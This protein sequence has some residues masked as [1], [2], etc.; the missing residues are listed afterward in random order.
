MGN[1]LRKNALEQHIGYGL[2]ENS[3]EEETNRVTIDVS[4][5]CMGGGK[6]ISSNIVEQIGE[7]AHA[8]HAGFHAK[9]VSTRRPAWTMHIRG[10]PTYK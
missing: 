1:I 3:Y 6:N 8:S 2:H 10:P 9:S 7:P 5:Q 4:M